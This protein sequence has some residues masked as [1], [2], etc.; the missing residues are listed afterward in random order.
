M[1]KQELRALALDAY[2]TKE[3][4]IIPT[5]KHSGLKKR[6]WDVIV[7]SPT[8]VAVGASIAVGNEEQRSEREREVY[9]DAYGASGSSGAA[10]EALNDFR[11]GR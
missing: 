10:M 2:A 3:I 1:N 4:A 8:K 5:G 6:D 9:A 11:M 7:R